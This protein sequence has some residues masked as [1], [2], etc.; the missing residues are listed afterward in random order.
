MLRFFNSLSLK[1]EAF[2]P[3]RDNEVRI[4]SCGPTVYDYAHIGNFRAYVFS[5]L[6]RRYLE[7]KGYGVKLVMNVTNVDDKTIK[8]ARDAGKTLA[9][10]TRFYEKSF[11]DDLQALEIKPAFAYPRATENVPQMIALIEKLLEKGIA[12]KGADGSVYYSIKKFADY[13]KL[14]RLRGLK[15]GASGRVSADDYEKENASDFALWKAHAPEDGEVFW[16]APFGKK[17]RP[18]WHIE[19]SA[20]SAHYLGQ[21]FDIHIG[22]V[23]LRFPHHENE[24]AQS[25]GASGKPLAR[26][27]MHNEHLLVDGQ[28]MAKR[29]HNFYTL[30]YVTAKGYSARAIRFLLISTHYR[31][32]LNFTFQALDAATNTIRKI[33][34]FYG[35]LEQASSAKENQTVAKALADCEKEFEK[36]MDD[37]FDVS[38]ALASVFEFVR[39]AN[40]AIDEGKLDKKTSLKTKLFFDKLDSVFCFIEKTASQ[41]L[42][43]DIAK[44]VEERENARKSKNFKRA[45][46]IRALLRKKGIVLED[47]P[48]G[49][50]WKKA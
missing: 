46:E 38:Q 27:W 42:D 19:C 9:E 17:G 49:V 28:K 20:M 22:G 26:F 47:T 21:P 18:G 48:K 12:Y 11:F 35:R 31:S 45:D 34:D 25:T 14:S 16:N 30:R 7:F 40:K 44:L 13:G 33:S 39:V 24:I 36:R 8:G 3:L 2:K 41:E 29:F 43:D 23:D 10:F 6:L 50:V 1:K 32:Q 15:T 37:D 5:D 4:Y